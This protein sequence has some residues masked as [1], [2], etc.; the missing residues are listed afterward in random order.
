[1]ATTELGSRVERLAVHRRRLGLPPRAVVFGGLVVAVGGGWLAGESPRIALGGTAVLL[2][3]ACVWARPEIAGYLV[4][5]VTPLVAGIDRGTAIPALRPN[6][7]LYFVLAATLV[8]RAIVLMRTG[9]WRRVRLTAVEWSLLLMAVANS[10]VPLLWMLLWHRTPSQDDYLY[11]LVL[12]KFVA[13]YAIVRASITTDRQIRRCLWISV[14]T[15]GVVA[16][17]GV[18]QSLDLL[19]VRGLLALY[20]AP[21]GYVGALSK[22]RGGS[23]L[24]LPA[25]TADLMIF[26]LAIVACFWMQG[27]RRAILAPAAVLLI[28]GTL[29][30]GEFSSFFGLLV[31][32]VAVA[33]VGRSWNI[34]LMSAPVGVAGFLVLWPVVAERLSGFQ[35]V[36]GLPASW[37]GRLHNLSSYFLPELFS[38]WNVLLGVRPAARVQVATQATGYVWIESGYIWLLWGGGIPLFAA[39]LFF[40]RASLRQGWRAARFGQGAGSIAGA[41]SVVAVAVCATLMVFDPHVTYRGSADLLFALLALTHCHRGETFEGSGDGESLPLATT[42]ASACT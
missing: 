8:T 36:H 9:Q 30:S 32:L 7:A 38:G 41:V 37:I 28:F 22:P 21:F 4:V 27:R 10:V 20:Y 35:S 19:G 23:T 34:P 16:L 39:Y 29:A 2:L 25:A 24:A 11:A 17:I 31:A 12:W 14:G 15:A 13:V 42:R 1:M 6:E 18:L 40:V 5:G 26:N 33:V 3:A